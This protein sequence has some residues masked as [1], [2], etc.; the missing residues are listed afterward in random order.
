YHLRYFENS[1]KPEITD[2]LIN[3]VIRGKYGNGVERKEKLKKL[4]FSDSDIKKIQSLVN[5]KLKEVKK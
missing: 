5:K 1:K 4:G 2:N 3:E